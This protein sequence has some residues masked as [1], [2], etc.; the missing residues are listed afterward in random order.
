MTYNE[1]VS[2]MES[3]FDP[4]WCKGGCFVL[5]KGMKWTRDIRSAFS[6]TL[7]ISE[8]RLIRYFVFSVKELYIYAHLIFLMY[9]ELEELYAWTKYVGIKKLCDN[10]ITESSTKYEMHKYMKLRL[11]VEL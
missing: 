1:L 7:I 6:S 2:S 4:F 5:N 9:S 11:P 10:R 3:H 8:Q